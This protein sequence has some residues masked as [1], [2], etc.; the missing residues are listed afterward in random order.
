MGDIPDGDALADDRQQTQTLADEIDGA[1][2]VFIATYA[3]VFNLFSRR[4]PR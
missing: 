1:D 3:P 2:T 4:V